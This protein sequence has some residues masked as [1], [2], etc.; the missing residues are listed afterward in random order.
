MITT[1]GGGGV[2]ASFFEQLSNK[3]LANSAIGIKPE[4]GHLDPRRDFW[5]GRE[6]YSNDFM[7]KREKSGQGSMSILMI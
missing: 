4:S 7:G 3:V 6:G 2:I 5:S 1:I